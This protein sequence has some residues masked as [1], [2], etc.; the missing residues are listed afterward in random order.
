MMSKVIRLKLDV[1]SHSDNPC[2]YPA[3]AAVTEPDIHDKDNN[4]N[5]RTWGLMYELSVYFIVCFKM[6]HY[7]LH[8]YVILPYV[9]LII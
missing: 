6:R 5:S 2:R 7:V 9:D 3:A 4:Y 8:A 1:H